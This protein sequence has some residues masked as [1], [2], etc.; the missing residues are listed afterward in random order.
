MAMKE[1]WTKDEAEYHGR[2]Y[3]F[4]P[5]RSL[6]KPAQ[7]P[8]PPMHTLTGYEVSS[9]TTPL[10]TS[11]IPLGRVGTTEDI[12]YGVLFLASDE[13]SFLTGSEMGI[14]G[15]CTAE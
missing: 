6:P 13:A 9:S 14:D 12:A 8:H 3:D 1:L 7:K 10:P 5:V 11:H 2:Y 15:G 4:P